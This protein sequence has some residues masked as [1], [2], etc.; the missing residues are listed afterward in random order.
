M[1][2]GHAMAWPISKTAGENAGLLRMRPSRQPAGFLIHSPHG[3]EAQASLRRLEPWLQA[4]S[5]RPSFETVD[6][7]APTSSGRDR[8]FIRSGSASPDRAS[9]KEWGAE[10][11]DEPPA[12]QDA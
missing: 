4:R 3:E 12:D 5:L 7:S 6:A 11:G 8:N 10:E 2:A 9:M 1:A